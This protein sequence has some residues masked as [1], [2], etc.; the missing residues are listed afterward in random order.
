[1]KIISC[2]FIMAYS[3]FAIEYYA[4]IEP[5]ESYI[6]KS[7]VSGKV[8][9]VNEEIEGKKAHNSTIIQIDDYVNKVELTQTKNKLKILNEMLKLE[10]NNYSRLKRVS[11]KSAFEKDTQKIKVLNLKTQKSDLLTKIATLEDT[12]KNKKLFE[13]SHY[14]YNIS[15]KEGDYVTPGTVLYES[16]DLSKGK[17]EIY[18]P[19]EDAKKV[20]KQ[21]IYINDKKTDL[22]INKIYEVADSKHISSYKTE[23][24]IPKTDIFSRLIKIEFK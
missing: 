17:V 13:K 11:S 19:L 9:Y 20:I 14:I 22:K 5:I 21:D 2:L 4:K 3:L 10:D 18:I 12:V 8:L 7:A 1:M 6:V 15:V 24:I 16:K 23:I